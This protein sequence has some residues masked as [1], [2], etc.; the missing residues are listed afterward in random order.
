MSQIFTDS[1]LE[2]LHNLSKQYDDV[3]YGINS[4]VNTEVNGD[5]NIVYDPQNGEIFIPNWYITGKYMTCTSFADEAFHLL[6]KLRYQNPEEIKSIA[7][8][9]GKDKHGNGHCSLAIS[10]IADARLHDFVGYHGQNQYFDWYLNQSMIFDL[11]YHE[12]VPYSSTGFKCIRFNYCT[13]PLWISPD[14]HGVLSDSGYNYI[15]I[16][17]GYGF[18]FI[19]DKASNS[20]VLYFKNGGYSFVISTLGDYL[21]KL[22]LFPWLDCYEVGNTLQFLWNMKI[23]TNLKDMVSKDKKMVWF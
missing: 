2:Y 11:C 10:P 7:R 1:T 14:Y 18:G 16:V 9:I 15:G 5:N 13:R 22:K 12:L 6:L 19:R 8:I 20:V 4:I 21:E 3:P 23:G 17:N